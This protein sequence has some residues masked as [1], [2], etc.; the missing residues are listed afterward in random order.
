MVACNAT[1]TTFFHIVKMF[2]PFP[3]NLYFKTILINPNGFFGNRK[4]NNS[5]VFDESE[6]IS[7]AMNINKEFILVHILGS[8][9]IIIIKVLFS[10]YQ[11]WKLDKW[12]RTDS[13]KIDANACKS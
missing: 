3:I 10:M 11:N 7:V 8:Y 2:R 13:I 1:Q 5:V 4:N 9:R 12:S 6:Q